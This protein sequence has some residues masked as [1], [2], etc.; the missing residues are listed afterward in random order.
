M[1]PIHGAGAEIHRQ[2]GEAR[3]RSALLLLR[4]QIGDPAGAGSIPMP[5][6]FLVELIPRRQTRSAAIIFDTA[7]MAALHCRLLTSG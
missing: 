1:G 6:F 2:W 3:R 5:I 4:L 7:A